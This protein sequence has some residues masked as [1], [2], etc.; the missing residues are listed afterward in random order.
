[1]AFS[2]TVLGTSGM[3]AT[4]ERACAGYLIDLAGKKLWLDGGP[5]TWRHLLNHVD[6]PDID[7][8]VVTHRHP[9]H[10]SDLFIAYHA[11][12]YGGPEPL[13][14]IP[15]YAPAETID[16][17]QGFVP[18]LGESFDLTVVAGG[19]VREIE[20]A[21]FSFVPMAH[22]PETLGVRI[23][24]GDAVFAYSADTGAEADFHTLAGGADVFVCEATLQDADE[25]WEGHLRASQAAAI[26]Q[27][28]DAQR[29]V[30]THLPPG[31][32]HDLSLNEA[33]TGAPEADIV[34]AV[35]GDRIEVGT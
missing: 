7:G 22:P 9:D 33:L 23:E 30:L 27:D 2:V 35:D 26:F 14:P 13:P 28:L 16:A 1:M 20:G 10:T 11:R 12:R 17:M 18:D 6:Y 29:L 8:I 19:E 31:R 4:R 15:L 34:L 24:Q 21:K 3:F 32:D 25:V 5:G